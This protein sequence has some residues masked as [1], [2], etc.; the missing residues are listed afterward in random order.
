MFRALP[1]MEA[2]KGKSRRFAVPDGDDR[3]MRTLLT[4]ANRFGRVSRDRMHH[5]IGGVMLPGSRL[6]H[7]PLY[8][9]KH[10]IITSGLCI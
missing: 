2:R 9:V 7:F 5:A 4:P 1:T 6:A 8:F 10:I 3:H